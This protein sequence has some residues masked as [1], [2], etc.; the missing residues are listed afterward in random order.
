MSDENVAIVRSIQPTE[1]VDLVELFAQGASEGSVPGNIDIDVVSDDAEIEFVGQAVGPLQDRRLRGV[2]GLIE[3]WHDWLEPWASYVMETEDVIDAGSLVVSLIH[4]TAKTLH[5]G[6]EVEH[7]PAAVWTVEGG[8]IVAVTF[9]LDRAQA[10]EAAGL[11]GRE[12]PRDG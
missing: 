1:R 12:P 4:V 11:S 6:V 9:Y 5:S 10:L 7:D 3:G 2:E 8:L